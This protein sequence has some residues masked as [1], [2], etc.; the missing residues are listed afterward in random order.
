MASAQAEDDQVDAWETI[1][2]EGWNWTTL[3]PYYF[4]CEQFQVPEDFQIANGITYNSA[5]YGTARQLKTGFLSDMIKG[6]IGTT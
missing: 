5:F 1:G 3:P 6:A 2:N 4:K